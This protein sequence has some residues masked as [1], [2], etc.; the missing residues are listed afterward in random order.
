MRPLSLATVLLALC[1]LPTSAQE[2]ECRNGIASLPDVGAFPCDGVNLVGYMSPARFAVA[3]SPAAAHNDIWGWT[4]PQTG[5][6]YAL[7]GTQNGLGFVDLSVPTS[8]RLVGK[9]PTP[10]GRSST[11]RDVKVYAD[12]AFVVADGSRDHGVQVFDLT[13]LRGATGEPVVFQEDVLYPQTSST[14]NIVINED[15]GYAYAVGYRYSPGERAA[16]GLPASCD[17]PGFH[18][19]DIRDP[20]NPT[21]VTCFS[22]AAIETGPR[23]PGYTH[24]AQ[25][26]VYSGPDTDHTG[27]ELCFGANEDVVTVFDVSDKGNIDILSQGEYPND[28]Y[29]HQGWLTEDQRYFIMNDEIDESSLSIPQ[30]TVVMDMEDLDSP[31]VAFIYDSG[32]NSVDHNLYTH[33][34]YAYQSN[35]ETGLRILDLEG[36]E[37]GTLT[38]V[39]FFDTFPQRDAISFNGQWSNYPYFE[40]GLVIVNDINNGFF[41][42]RPTDLVSVDA[43]EPPPPSGF[44]LGEPTPNP[45]ASG[46]RLTLRVDEVQSVRAE[47]FDIAGRRITTAFDGTVGSGRATTIQVDRGDLPAG[48]YVLRVIG[49]RFEASRRIV[50]TR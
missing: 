5:I 2:V 14:H 33:G 25:C 21:F 30:R 10:N 8:P 15:T 20:K 50:F 40:S 38:E 48:V 16:R 1:A 43:E 19:I 9:M 11:W 47:L 49:E 37:N 24:D 39:A 45:T 42:L 13:R 4:D 17:E 22:D 31:E 35:Y 36:I 7:V 46:A 6:E 41:V 32:L 29:T 44:E 26:V 3:G 23:T 18:V 12:H 28:V 34:R 27:K